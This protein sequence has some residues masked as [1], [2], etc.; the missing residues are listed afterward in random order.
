MDDSLF[1][2]R[3]VA[4]DEPPAGAY[5]CLGTALSVRRQYSRGVHTVYFCRAHTPR[6]PPDRTADSNPLRDRTQPTNLRRTSDA[7]LT[8]RC[9]CHPT[10]ASPRTAAGQSKQHAPHADQP[11]PDQTRYCAIVCP[12]YLSSLTNPSTPPCPCTAPAHTTLPTTTTIPH[13]PTRSNAIVICPA[14]STLDSA[15]SCGFGRGLQ[16][17]YSVCTQNY[18]N[19]LTP[20]WLGLQCGPD[21]VYRGLHCLGAGAVRTMQNYT[22]PP[23]QRRHLHQLRNW[24]AVDP[25]RARAKIS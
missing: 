11:S 16:V 25:P 22:W 7:R 23:S 21:V 8:A 24:H 3:N 5:I 19:Q 2:G 20:G 9:V 10:A 18:I 13:L 12:S 4:V 17:S 1:M 14:G 15:P 6:S